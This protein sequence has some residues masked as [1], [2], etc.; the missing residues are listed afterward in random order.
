MSLVPRWF[1]SNKAGPLNGFAML[2]F[3]IEEKT[4]ENQSIGYMLAYIRDS[5][6]PGYSPVVK[7]IKQMNTGNSDGGIVRKLTALADYEGKTRVIAIGDLLSNALLKPCHDVIMRCLNGLKSDYTHKQH[8][9]S[10][11][12]LFEFEEPVSVDLTAATD[13]IPAIITKH[14][15]GEYF[16]DQQF[17]ES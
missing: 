16:A 15:L 3:L 2:S 13:R 9:L 4:Y 11:I 10:D 1:W 5:G 6:A 12:K 7:H 17:A 8:T 14:I